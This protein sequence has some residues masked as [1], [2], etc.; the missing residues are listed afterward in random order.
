MIRPC[1]AV[2]LLSLASAA[3]ALEPVDLRTEHRAEPVGVDRTEPRLSWTL[4]ADERDERQTAYRILVA[5]TEDFLYDNVGDLW[6]SGRVETSDSSEIAYDGRALPPHTRCFWTVRVWDGEGQ[7]SEWSAPA[8]FVTGVF[9]QEDWRAAWIG[10][11]E[12]REVD[13]PEAPLEGASWIWAPGE[14]HLDSRRG[15]RDFQATWTL[16]ADEPL[17]SA[18]MVIRADDS[19]RLYVNGAQAT[20]GGRIDRTYRLDIT[21]LVDPGDNT[22]RLSVGHRGDGPAGVVAKFIATTADGEEHVLATGDQWRYDPRGDGEPQAAQV[23][24]EYGV[25]PWGSVG[26]AQ[27]RTP[28]VILLRDEFEAHGPVR[29]AI[30]YTTALG[31]CDVWLNGQRVSDE[32][33]APGWTDYSKRVYYSAYDVTRNVRDGANALGAKLADGWYSGHVGWARGAGRKDH[34]GEKPRLGA[35]LVVE[36]E[37]GAVETFATDD[38]WRAARSGTLAGDFLMGETHD[39]RLEPSGWS[40]PGFDASQWSAVDTGAEVSPVIQ[41]RQVQPVTVART[42]A[43]VAVTEPKPGLYVLDLGQNFAGVARL[44]LQDTEPGQK[45]TL[46]FAERLNPDGTVYL[47]NLRSAQATDTY[48]CRGAEEETWQPRFTFHGFQYVEVR[49]LG[50]APEGDEVVGLALSSDTPDV[51]SFECSDPMLNQLASNIYWTQRAN[52]IDIPTDCPQRDERLGWT[53]DAQVYVGSA[54]LLTDVHAFFDKWLVDLADAQREDGQ[55]PT[56]APLKVSSGDG[57]PAWADAGNIC[58]WSIYQTYGDKQLLERQYPSM[59]RFVEFRERRSKEG[60]LPPDRFHCFGDWLSINANTPTE[61]IYTAYHAASTKIVADAARVL[62]KTEDAERFDELHARIKQAFNDAYVEP[63]GTIHGDTQ[64]CYVLALAN[65]L[66]DEEK[67]RLAGQRLV[68]DILQR[69]GRLSTGFVGTKDL[70]LVLAKIGRHDVAYQLLHNDE[71]PSWGFSIKH[72]ATSI[73]ERWDGWTPERGFQDAGMNSFAHYSFGAV[74]RFMVENLSG[75]RALAP[76]YYRFEVA[77]VIDP[78]LTWAKTTYDSPRGR[79]ESS[80]RK[81]DGELAIRVVVPANTR[82]VV[83]LP[84]GVDASD[85]TESGD[86]LP[87]GWLTAESTAD[88]RAALELGGGAYEF[89]MPWVAE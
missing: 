83:K 51:G 61:V 29:S 50:R 9:D 12:L 10:A 44:K 58:P 26:T 8:S 57:G 66:L 49:G 87:A 85:A 63:D 18:V 7:A 80:W 35:Q 4:E 77:P 21:H 64:C 70:M 15:D 73:W 19:A 42:F 17:K 16:P 60:V 45:I 33:F 55:F 25:E 67:A 41:W 20:T 69:G 81:R 32:Y 79:I 37:D 59:K 82:A 54:S 74:Y 38:S 5:T 2:I 31:V 13:R 28:P 34:Y 14:D 23:I 56:V 89:R 65:D 47:T 72:G 68:E 75:V 22:L 48:I 27:E 71:F 30:L 6:D 39:A 52:F 11:D 53:G 88:Q 3:C 24:G 78:H 46:R 40:E 86:A 36:Y 84:E 1:A 62:G 43:P 76:G